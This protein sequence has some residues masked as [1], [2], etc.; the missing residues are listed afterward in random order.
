MFRV[1][2][3]L[4][5]ISLFIAARSFAVLWLCALAFSAG[6]NEQENGSLRMHGSVIEAACTINT[7][8]NEQS[9]DIGT[10]PISKILRDGKGPG[11]PFHIRLTNCSPLGVTY[12]QKRLQGVHIIFDGQAENRVLFALEGNGSGE[13]IAIT[14]ADGLQIFPGQTTPE[15]DLDPGRMI[16]DYTLWLTADYQLLRPGEFYTTI[17]YFMEY[18]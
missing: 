9:I 11:I 15:T 17:R 18:D 7:G 1:F 5:L 14:D 6:A 2:H 8:N 13:G 12:Q 10:V 3:G 16:L 4:P